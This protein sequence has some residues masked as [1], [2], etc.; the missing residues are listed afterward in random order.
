MFR[1]EIDD[2]DGQILRSVDV[3]HLLAELTEYI[4]LE[5]PRR[6]ANSIDMS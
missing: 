6:D 2:F 1:T 3:E 4:V 5:V